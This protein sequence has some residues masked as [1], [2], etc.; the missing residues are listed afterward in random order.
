MQK[1]NF[2]TLCRAIRNDDVALMQCTDAKT[3]ESVAVICV[4]Q[5]RES[6]DDAIE[7][8]PVA[9]LMENPYAEVIPPTDEEPTGGH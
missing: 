1:N 5:M 6:E 4:V 3:G 2:E 9:R 8:I 7:F